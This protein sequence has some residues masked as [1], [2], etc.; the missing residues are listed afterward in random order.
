MKRNIDAVLGSNPLLWC[1][2]RP[3]SGSGVKFELSK[4]DGE[5][6]HLTAM[7]NL[8]KSSSSTGETCQ[9]CQSQEED[10]CNQDLKSASPW[11]YQNEG[12]N[13]AL[14]PSNA[15]LRETN[16]VARRRQRSRIPEGE[17]ASDVPPYH[18]DYNRANENEN[19]LYD[20]E[21]ED[22]SN[23]DANYDKARVRRGS[24]GY[25]VRQINREDV[26]QRYLEELG[27]KP[28]RYVK[29]MPQPDDNDR[30]EEEGDNVPLAYLAGQPNGDDTTFTK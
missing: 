12:F 1:W 20:G 16:S 18:P 28:G 11:T 15:S 4:N 10:P 29:Y 9:P 2:P 8:L 25:E 3:P 24:E 22:S 21:E 6:Y 13:P 14:Q 26:L 30:D 27:E 23:E 17:D 19:G 7:P 5:T